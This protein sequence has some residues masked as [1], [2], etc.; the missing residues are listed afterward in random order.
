MTLSELGASIR[1]ERLR[2]GL[3]LF[4]AAT[5]VRPPCHPNSVLLAERG[6]TSRVMAARIA[7]A[8][9]VTLSEDGQ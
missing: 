3:S 8:L 5:R 4:R 9:G 2:L 6:A 7:R 1:E